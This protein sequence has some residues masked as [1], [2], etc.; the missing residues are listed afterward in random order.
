M[1][2]KINPSVKPWLIA[3]H[4]SAEPAHGMMLQALGLQ[5]VVSLGMRLG[6]G[7]GAAV[8][9]PL[10]QA[11][12]RLQSEMASFNEAGVSEKQA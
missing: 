12:C 3:S 7:S 6:E 11:A 4:Q 2:L 1:A 9:V 5:P 10:L 8:V